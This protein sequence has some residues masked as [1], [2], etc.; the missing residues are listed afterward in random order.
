MTIANSVNVM[1]SSRARDELQRAIEDQREETGMNTVRVMVQSGG[2]GCNSGQF[3]M[4]FDEEQFDDIRIDLDGIVLLV[5]PESAPFLEGAEMDYSDD[6]MGRG[7]K[8]NAPNLV[9]SGGGGG[10]CGCGGGGCGCGGH[11]H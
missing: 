3:A 8:I 5:D 11:S 4:G 10:G 1:I 7:F 2:C 9:S 6:L